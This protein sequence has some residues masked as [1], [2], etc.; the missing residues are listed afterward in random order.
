VHLGTVA[1][2]W[3]KPRAGEVALDKTLTPL[4]RQIPQKAGAKP[5]NT[6]WQALAQYDKVPK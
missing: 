4:Y 1:K 2:T 3:A 6:A 5:A